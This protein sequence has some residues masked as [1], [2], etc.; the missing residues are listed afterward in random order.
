M[1][2]RVLFDKKN[3]IV[4]MVWSVAWVLG[5]V[6][7]ILARAKWFNLCGFFGN[8]WCTLEGEKLSSI[9]IFILT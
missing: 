9:I 5:V 8:S 3:M 2:L 4:D 1:L 6:C 7:W